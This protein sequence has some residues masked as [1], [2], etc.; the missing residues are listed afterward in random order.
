M[1]G[2]PDRASLTAARHFG[3][4]AS[5]SDRDKSRSHACPPFLLLLFQHENCHGLRQTEPQSGPPHQPGFSARLRITQA[6]A[7]MA[8]GDCPRASTTTVAAGIGFMYNPAPLT[9]LLL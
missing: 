1:S 6:T 5:M 8:R 3:Y 4:S 7:N 9:R 2:C